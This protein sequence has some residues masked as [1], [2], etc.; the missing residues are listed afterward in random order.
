MSDGERGLADLL[1]THEERFGLSEA[2]ALKRAERILAALKKRWLAV[3]AV[4]DYTEPGIT[5]Q[6]LMAKYAEHSACAASESPGDCG[7]NYTMGASARCGFASDWCVAAGPT[8]GGVSLDI[9]QPP[10]PTG[11]FSR[12]A[13]RTSEAAAAAGG[14]LAVLLQGYRDA[15]GDLSVG[16]NSVLKRL[17]ATARRDVFDPEVRVDWDSSNVLLREEELIRSLIRFAG[18]SDDDLRELM[19]VARR[20]LGGEDTD[21]DGIAGTTSDDRLRMLSRLIPYYTVIQEDQIKQMLDAAAGNS[22]RAAGVLAELIRQVEWIDEQLHRLGRTGGTASDADVRHIA[23]TSLIGH[24]MIDLK[25][26]TDP[27][28]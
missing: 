9:K 7:L 25:A 8:W 21:G 27:A 28:R 1:L 12:D 22:A 23:I 14:A 15:D 4:G 18:A 10:H 20:E 11:S 17:K 24:G 3:V 13:Y 26:A 5:Y 16:T 2:E 6:A 19:D